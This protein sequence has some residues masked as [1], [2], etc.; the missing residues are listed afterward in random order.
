MESRECVEWARHQAR[1]DFDEYVRERRAKH[2]SIK[3]DWESFINTYQCDADSCQSRCDDT[4]RQCF[5]ICGGAVNAK[6]VCTAFCDPPPPPS[7]IVA[8][9]PAAQ[10]P[11]P[12][13]PAP[14]PAKSGPT[15]SLC[16]KGAKVQAYSENDWYDAAVKA[17][18]L[19]DGRCAVHHVDFDDDE[20]ET[21]L[22]SM[23]RPRP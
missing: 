12:Q 13:A 15:K 10:V 2:L 8:P 11:P 23:L 16:V 4:Y 6:Q 18:P 1:R 5:S 19:P 20:D 17:P 7:P 9:A 3:R 14:A 21:V 22:P